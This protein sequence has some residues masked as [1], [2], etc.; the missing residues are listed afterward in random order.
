MS[1][2]DLQFPS[3][4]NPQEVA[5]NRQIVEFAR[6]QGRRLFLVG[7][8]IRDALIGK[9]REGNDFKPSRDFDYAI[10]GGDAFSFAKAVAPMV[11]GHFVPLDEANDT[12]RVVLPD[13]T[14]LDFAGCVGGNIERD[15]RRRDFSIN[16][17]FWDPERPKEINDLVGGTDDI[18]AGVVRAIDES[19][20]L[21][22]PLRILRAYRFAAS[23]GFQIESQTAAWVARHNQKLA[24]VAPERINHELFIALAVSRIGPLLLDMG[25]SG[26][27]ETIFPELAETRNV[28]GNTFHHLGLFEHSLETVIQAEETLAERSEWPATNLDEELSFGVTRLAALK[29]ACLLHDIG[30]PKTWVITPEGK[31]TF[32]GHDRLGADMVVTIAERQK[33]SRPVERFIAKLVK[34]HLRPGQLFHQGEPTEKAVL[35]F[36]RNGGREL[37]ELIL[38]ALGDLG[39]TRG[40][41]MQG[42][43]NE[44]LRSFLF[45]LLEG[46]DVFRKESE[47]IPK[48]LDGNEIMQLLNLKPGPLVGELLTALSEAQEFKEVGNRADAE[49]FITELYKLRRQN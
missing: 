44:A 17:L 3:G 15:I 37:P 7:G 16:A 20:F 32:I 40:P 26:V 35:R 10:A 12:A 43:K 25:A 45:E 13:G 9:L 14:T 4:T 22:D 19:A 8:Y 18:K 30:K 34:W 28:T 5:L 33:W 6:S 23:L 49:R 31:H 29:L 48:L 11:E 41:A 27:L 39:A 1:K 47:Q 36:Y 46:F 42:G 21:D 24:Q 2:S 38:L